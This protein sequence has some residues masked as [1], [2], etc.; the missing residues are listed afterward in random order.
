MRITRPGQKEPVGKRNHAVIL[1]YLFIISHSA[2]SESRGGVM[3]SAKNFASGVI[4]E[5]RWMFCLLRSCSMVLPNVALAWSWPGWNTKIRI[6]I[7]QKLGD[8]ARPPILK[9]KQGLRPPIVRWQN[10]RPKPLGEQ[11]LGVKFWTLVPIFLKLVN[12]GPHISALLERSEKGIQDIQILWAKVQ[13]QK[14]YK[15]SN[16]ENNSN[17]LKISEIKCLISRK[18][19]GVLT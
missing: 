10:C 11:I 7:P 1:C 14:S 9:L 17:F 8:G 18:R 15:S 5:R 4:S 13:K 19:F 12:F 2:W 3:P 16:F 6:K